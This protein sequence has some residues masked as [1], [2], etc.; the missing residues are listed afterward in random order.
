MP[1]LAETDLIVV[2]G[3]TT[4]GPAAVGAV[5]NGVRTLL[6]EQLFELGGVQTAGMI[7]G[8]YFG[9]QRGF[10]QEI[11]DGV[12]ET[13]RFKSQAKA[14][15]YRASVRKGGGE[16]WFGSMAVGAVME[17]KRLRGVVV[18]TPDGTR[19]VSGAYPRPADSPGAVL[20]SPRTHRPPT[21]QWAPGRTRQPRMLPPSTPAMRARPQPRLR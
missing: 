8:Y 7:C 16:I 17:G 1:V 6:I 18:V 15:W 20:S 11:D 2:G 13:G 3:G 9:N 14:E 5:K 10:T 21:R 12:K 19:A 4:G